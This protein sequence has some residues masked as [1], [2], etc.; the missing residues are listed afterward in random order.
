MQRAIDKYMSRKNSQNVEHS[1][2]SLKESESYKEEGNKYFRNGNF[3]EA[4][5]YYTMAINV[6][7]SSPNNNV[8]LTNRATAA[9]YNK[10]YQ[11][12]VDGGSSEFW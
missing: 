3:E 10:N 7:P 5:K 11:S 6:N 12:A 1:A 9:F 2:D 4:I 8:Y